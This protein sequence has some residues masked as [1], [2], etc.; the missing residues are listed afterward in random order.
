MFLEFLAPVWIAV[1]APRVFKT[2]TEPVVYGGL[3][4]ALAG[5]VLILMPML[6]GQ[7][8]HISTLGVVAGL[9]S[10]LSQIFVDVSSS[11]VLV[12][13]FVVLFLQ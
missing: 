9:V 5:L 7:G 1:V 8:V 4:I 3:A 11:Q 2:Q 6:R 10:A 13:L 12:L